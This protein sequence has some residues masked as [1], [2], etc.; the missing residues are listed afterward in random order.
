[1]DELADLLRDDDKGRGTDLTLQLGGSPSGFFPF[2]PDKGDI[3]NF[4]VR[5]SRFNPGGQRHRPWKYWK[6]SI[7]LSLKTA[8]A[9]SVTDNLDDGTLQIGTVDGLRYPQTGFDVRV[10]Y[11]L[12]NL[13]TLDGAGHEI[14]MGAAADDYESFYTFSGNTGKMGALINYLIG[15]ARGSDSVSFIPDTDYY[16]FGIDKPADLA[17]NVQFIYTELLANRAVLRVSHDGFDQMSFRCGMRFISLG[18]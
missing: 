15:T 4:T 6:P 7:D 13:T 14:N 2:G 12:N 5:I 9:Y 3:G 1:M 17:F 8:P 16:P 10:N 18:G 11:A